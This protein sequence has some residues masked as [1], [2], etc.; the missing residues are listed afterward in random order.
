MKLETVPISSL[1]LDPENARKHSQ[2]NIDAIAGSLTTF[3]QR[4]PLV[5]WENIIIAGNGTVEAAKS[6]GWDKIEITRVP[7]D[8]THDQARAYALADNRTAELAEWDNDI[9]ASQLIELDSV[10]YE[11]GDWG[12]EPLT[13]PEEID[14]NI[15]E[16]FITPP[17]NPITKERDIWKL[18]SHR[19]MCGDSRNPKD[20][21][22]L[23]NG[24]KINL[25]I[26]SP[27]Y[28]QQRNYDEKSGFTPIPPEEYVEWFKPVSDQV[29]KNLTLDGSWF[30]NI[31]AASEGLSRSLYV[32]DLVTSHAR[33][34]GW[35]FSEEF[36]WERIGIP[37]KP[38]RRFKNQWESVFQFTLND[39][40]FRPEKVMTHTSSSFKY[41]GIEKDWKA[42]DDQ[43]ISENQSKL[44]QREITEGMAYPGNRLPTFSGSHEA[45]GHSAAFPVGLPEFFIKAYTDEADTI[46]DPFMGSGSTLLAAD[47]QNRICYGMEISPAYCDVIIQRWENKTG[48]KA[49]RITKE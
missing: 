14:L 18:G 19:I 4:R 20:V 49:E 17:V 7:T 43:G 30:I 13:P 28:A 10:G 32:M 24:N 35:N 40:K 3:G 29:K 26:T 46:Y 11:I 44:R 33:K 39:W 47:Q 48:T 5:V 45:L 31:K 2:K 12:F 36:C 41:E 22:E 16:D 8:W 9:L 42:K 27:P 21:E 1:T 6:I 38:T 34:W 25:A 37:G 23:L 15:D